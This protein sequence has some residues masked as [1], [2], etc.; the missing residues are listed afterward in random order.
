MPT[1]AAFLRGINL[2]RRR[3]PMAQ[4]RDLFVEMGFT[5][6]STFIAS[7]NVLFDAEEPDVA[8]MEASVSAHL[9]ASLGYP[10]ATFIRSIEALD[11]IVAAQPFAADDVAR[12]GHNV[13]VSFFHDVLD[14][15]AIS[16]VNALEKEG[17]DAFAVVGREIYWLARGRLSDSPV[18]MDMLAK[19]VGKREG[20]M[21]NMNT[22]RRILDKFGR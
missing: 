11:E 9:H 14:S 3:P 10:V 5:N 16:R 20:T 19:A 1:Y 4:L 8:S 18:T 15:G 12:P 2:G 13:H 6:V 21:R 17:R 7:G 22:L